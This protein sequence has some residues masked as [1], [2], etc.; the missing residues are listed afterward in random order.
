MVNTFKGIENCNT[1]EAVN[2]LVSN[3]DYGDNAKFRFKVGDSYYIYSM[4]TTLT[5]MMEIGCSGESLKAG[6]A[7]WTK[8]E[9]MEPPEDTSKYIVVPTAKGTNDP[10]MTTSAV[11]QD[12]SNRTLNGI[13]YIMGCD[14]DNVPYLVNKFSG[15]S[16]CMSIEDVNSLVS[17]GNNAKY[18]FK[19]GDKYYKYSMS[20]TDTRLVRPA[21][22]DALLEAGSPVW[23]EV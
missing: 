13:Y 9:S 2:D 14:F 7:I 16:E 23:T 20:T 5:S 8:D 11:D 6:A 12:I 17:R 4:S 19:I 22:S 21:C 10:L 18:M 1:I 3:G 15:I